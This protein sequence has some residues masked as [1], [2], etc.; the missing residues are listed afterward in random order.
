MADKIPFNQY[1]PKY[2]PTWILM[3]FLRLL[4]FLP[5]SQLLRVGRGLGSGFYYVATYRRHITEVNLKLCFPELSDSERQRLAK[6]SFQQMGMGV[7]DSV[8]SWWGNPKHLENKISFYG[9]EHYENAKQ[10][11]QGIIAFSA[12]FASLEM[13]GRLAGKQFQLSPV[14]RHHRNPVYNRIVNNARRNYARK[15]ID[16]NDLRTIC[17]ELKAKKVVWYAPD[18]D[19]GATR[20]VFA[21]FFG[22]ETA[23]LKGTTRLAKLT[24]ATVLPA[25]FFR[26]EKD[27]TQHYAVCLPPLDNFPSGDDVLD[28]TRCNACIE[29]IVRQHPSQYLWMHRRFKTRPPGQQSP[30][31]KKR[32]KLRRF[33]KELFKGIKKG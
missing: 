32:K 2:W 15:I 19:F 3:G 4:A 30:Y 17:R 12:H 9:L 7:M 29:E 23:T 14:F 22:I 10:K 24:H 18:Q 8:Y 21:P 13:A 6:Q 33:W 31:L 26:D 25:F 20:S 1:A 5:Y 27:P 11:G 28:A 16:R